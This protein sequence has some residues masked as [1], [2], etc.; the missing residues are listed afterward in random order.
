MV[1]DTRSA[2]GA[3]VSFEI[4]LGRSRFEIGT[5]PFPYVAGSNP[6]A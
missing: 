5:R 2:A 3:A 6:F 1:A 4:S